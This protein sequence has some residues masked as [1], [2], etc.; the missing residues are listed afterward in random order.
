MASGYGGWVNHARYR[1][2]LSYSPT[3]TASTG[4]VNVRLRIWYETDSWRIDDPSTTLTVSGSFS[5]SQ[6]VYI[7][8][9]TTASSHSQLIY[10]RTISVATRY[11]AAVG[12]SFSASHSG[13][14]NNMNPSASGSISIPARPYTA[15]AKPTNV[16]ARRVTDAQIAVSFTTAS[17]TAAPV[18]SAVIER[19]VDGGAFGA[20]VTV[21]GAGAKTFTDSGTAAGHYYQYR[22]AAKGN[23]GTS[24][25]VTSPIVYT[26]PLAPTNVAATKSGMDI[27]LSWVNK[28][29]GQVTNR[30][31]EGTSL[32]AN[33]A[34][35]ATSFLIAA[36]TPTSPHS[37]SVVA[38]S[39]DGL[40]SPRST[41]N[42]VQLAL[43]PYPPTN[44]S[45]NST[46]IPTGASIELAWSYNSADTSEQTRYEIQTATNPTNP[47]WVTIETTTTDRKE[48][49]V[50]AGTAAR[51]FLWRVRTWGQDDTKPSPFSEP[52][53]I[54]VVVPPTITITAPG[55]G[56]VVDKN[57][58]QI[59]LNTT[60][61][62]NPLYWET[63]LLDGS[64]EIATGSGTFMTKTGTW[65]V[66]GLENAHTYT[67]TARVGG[68]VWSNHVTRAFTVTYAAPPQ[69]S[70]DGSYQ[71][72][73]ASVQL[74][75]TNPA[76]EPAIAYNIVQR[77][78]GSGF[79]TIAENVRANTV[80]IDHT[81]PLNADLF[82]RVI[83][84]STLGTQ[85]ISATEWV[86]KPRVRGVWLNWGIDGSKK[87]HLVWNVPRATKPELVYANEYVFAGHSLPTL[88]A[89][90]VV[91]RETTISAYLGKHS[92]KK[93]RQAVSLLEEAALADT[94]VILRRGEYPSL[95]GYISGISLPMDETGTYTV[96]LTHIQ[97][98]NQP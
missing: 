43:A 38:V 17:T 57:T 80:L 56:G 26:T 58:T 4:A 24:T 67:V 47:T 22:V 72:A 76:G 68:K 89:G 59:L 78:H 31:Y 98:D 2:D 77:S 93:V 10:D 41:S 13:A 94:P 64:R 52:A 16:T 83:A 40:E 32:V 90:D 69:P 11:G 87:V 37:Y 39:P 48:T 79:Y 62:E 36:P 27:A 61:S 35:D 15:P 75:I 45:P 25:T 5:T 50:A 71:D 81:P 73:D 86:A 95:S 3:V 1:W 55:E 74:E 21:N 23:G 28:A 88:V 33:L 19:S 34:G 30:I 84:V 14:W 54:D 6:T 12:V 46:Y 85:S 92:E 42:L 97:T 53:R 70:I 96:S 18:T 63:R 49:T 60:S 82:Y 66:A 8:L 29:R 20:L 44:L 7:N 9:M 91:R 51:S 65:N